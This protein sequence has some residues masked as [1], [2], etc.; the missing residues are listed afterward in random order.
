LLPLW[1]DIWYIAYYV[2]G[3]EPIM[4]DEEPIMGEV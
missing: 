1:Y 2:L 3:E 4:A